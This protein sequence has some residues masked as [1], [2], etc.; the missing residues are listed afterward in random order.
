VD[1]E[2]DLRQAVSGRPDDTVAKRLLALAEGG[3]HLP[4]VCGSL[5]RALAL[6]GGGRD[7]LA[8]QVR[9]AGEEEDGEDN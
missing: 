4:V 3:A 8:D 1:S 6:A 2:D 5:D 7:G 9:R